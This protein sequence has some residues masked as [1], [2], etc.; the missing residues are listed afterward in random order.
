MKA[1]GIRELKNRL[2]RYVDEVR[3]GEVILVTDRNVVVAELRPPSAPAALTGHPG[4]DR[5][6][7][8]GEV[9][10]GKPHD[11]EIYRR[12]IGDPLPAGTAQAILDE[13]R[14]DK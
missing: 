7:A 5:M 6:I 2:S 3:K 11:P 14:R 4:L 13:L 9:R 10:A 12:R 8:R 1:V